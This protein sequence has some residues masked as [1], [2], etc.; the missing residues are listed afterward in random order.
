MAKRLALTGKDSEVGLAVV[1]GGE[2]R[3]GLWLLWLW[4]RLAL[5]LLWL[6]HVSA[7][8]TCHSFPLLASLFLLKN[9]PKEEELKKKF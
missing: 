2:G 5:F 3:W 7:R 1:K 9:K 4:G 8:L 6:G